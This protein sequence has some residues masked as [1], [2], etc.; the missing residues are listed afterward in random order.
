[1]ADGEFIDY[2]ELLMVSP[3]A[4]RGMIEWAARLMLTRY[5]KKG[6]KTADPGKCEQV[7]D[8]YKTLVKPEEREAYDKLHKQH[9]D[10]SSTSGNGKPPQLAPMPGRE[11]PTLD[12]TTIRLEP[13]AT[14][15]DVEVNKVLRQA[16][17]STLYDV[18]VTRPRN[19]EADRVEIARA[20]GVPSD[21][22]EVTLWFLRES[23]MMRTTN[24]G[25]YSITAKGVEWA[26]A[27]GIPHLCE[28]P[29]GPQVVASGTDG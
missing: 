5:G 7:K 9:C 23:G 2:Y 1:M 22:L 27:G 16:T 21:D 28:D 19:P 15:R 3:R 26:E 6:G 8:A 24:Q 25:A 10:S 18:L 13:L 11:A 4:D 29:P 20:L 12:P 14:P 17:L